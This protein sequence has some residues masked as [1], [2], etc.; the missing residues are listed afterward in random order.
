MK[1]SNRFSFFLKVAS[2]MFFLMFVSTPSSAQDEKEKKA[3]EK[4]ED[5]KTEMNGGKT[6]DEIREELIKRHRSGQSKE[7]LKR[8]KRSKREAERRKKGK[9]PKPWWERMFRKKR[10]KKKRKKRS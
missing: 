1:P 9:N 5:R 8:M 6:Q 7:T 3:L 2:V 10:R 4:A